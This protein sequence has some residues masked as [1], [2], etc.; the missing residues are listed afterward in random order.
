M[1]PGAGDDLKGM[2]DPL[3]VRFEADQLVY[4]MRA[5]ANARDRETVT[6]YVLAEHRVQKSAQ[7]G[8]SHIAFADWIEPSALSQGSALAPFVNRKLFLTK[9]QETVYPN[10]VNDDFVF[11]FASQDETY[12]DYIV[13]YENDYTIFALA[14]LC[15][16][17]LVAVPVLLV[18][19]LLLFGVVK[20][21]Q[22]IGKR[23]QP[24]T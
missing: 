18:V 5:S 20:L 11:A 22:R 21:A 13:E 16:V 4:P 14:S 15:L 2:L 7:F 17:A 1:R 8:D 3:W 10:R 9:F 24:T 12:H 19:G 23:S 6:V